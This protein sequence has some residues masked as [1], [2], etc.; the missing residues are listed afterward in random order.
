MNEQ[1]YDDPATAGTES[2]RTNLGTSV[3]GVFA[4]LTP[5]LFYNFGTK[6]LHAQAGDA[7]RIG[8]GLGIGYL[9]TSG[10]LQFT[11]TTGAEHTF[12]ESSF[13]AAYNLLLEYRSGRLVSRLKASGPTINGGDYQY[14]LSDTY[15]SIG[16][17]ID[18]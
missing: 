5:T 7:F 12:D 17:L 6:R 9:S 14:S 10:S 4:Y 16:Y 13:G 15:I 11:E 2:E 18:I 3:N 1:L 8:V